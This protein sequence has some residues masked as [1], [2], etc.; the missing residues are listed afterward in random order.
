M[1]PGRSLP[2]KAIGR[3]C[4]PVARTTSRAR[5][6][7]SRWRAS[8][9]ARAEVSVP[10]SSSTTRP[11][12][13]LPTAV[14]QASTRSSSNGSMLRRV[15]RAAHR[16]GSRGRRSAPRPRRPRARRGRPRRR[17]RRSGRAAVVAAWVARAVERPARRQARARRARRAARPGRLH[18]RLRRRAHLDERAGL[19]GAGGRRSRAG[20][21]GGSPA[22]R[23]ARR[24]EQRG[25]ER[26]AGEA[27]QGRRR[28]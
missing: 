22:R 27:R 6:C 11:W 24:G 10:R 1:T 28:T 4:A 13:W 3:S 2:A 17:A 5:T 14:V 9:G 19:L 7:H 16:P 20:G 26:V 15:A 21:R 12:S 23:R 25:G 18:H 8:G